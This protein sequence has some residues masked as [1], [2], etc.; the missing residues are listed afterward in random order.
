MEIARRSSAAT[1]V[2]G[3]GWTGHGVLV[4]R[5]FGFS[6]VQHKRFATIAACDRRSQDIGC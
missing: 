4:S 5:A 3:G 2:T 6:S 1:A